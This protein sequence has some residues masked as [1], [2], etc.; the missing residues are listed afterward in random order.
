MR[1]SEKMAYHQLWR[2]AHSTTMDGLQLSWHETEK[3][4]DQEIRIIKDQDP[5]ASVSK[6]LVPVPSTRKGIV[7]WLNAHYETD[8]G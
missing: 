4:A 2:V 5:E 1:V 3:K 6:S 7:R 8:N